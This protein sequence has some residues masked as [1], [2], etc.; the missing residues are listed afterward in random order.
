MKRQKR[1]AAPISVPLQ[2]IT[3]LIFSIIALPLMVSV[4]LF[5]L[6]TVQNQKTSIREANKSV[7]N[8]YRA[9]LNETLSQAESY[10]A[11]I[12]ANDVDFKCIMYAKSQ[13]EMYLRS[14]ELSKRSSDVLFTSPMITG[15]FTY[16]YT[17]DTPRFSYNPSVNVGPQGSENP[18]DYTWDDHLKIK[19]T[20]LRAGESG[21]SFPQWETLQLSGRRV[22]IYICV[23][24]RTAVGVI[25][26]PAEQ[27]YA[28]LNEG[29]RIFYTDEEGVP[30]ASEMLRSKEDFPVGSQENFLD[31]QGE[32]CALTALPLES[33]PGYIAYIS[34]ARSFIEELDRFQSGL[35]LFSICLILCIPLCWLVLVFTVF[36]PMSQ[37]N[38]ISKKIQAGE[39]EQRVSVDSVVKEVQIM[40]QSVNLMLDTIQRQR[41]AVYEQQLETQNAQIQYLQL[42]I[43]PHFFLNCLNMIYSLAEEKKSAQIQTL[44]IDFSAY[45]RA[46]FKDNS[47]LVTV[48]TELK[49]VES[50]IRIQKSGAQMPVEL[51]LSI[52]AGLLSLPI[53]AL[54]LL[55]FVENS[56]KHGSIQ[57]EPLSI[58]I[59]GFLFEEEGGGTYLNFSICDNGGGFRPESLESLNEPVRRVYTGQHV[60]ITNIKY[61]LQFLY[62]GRATMLLSNLTNG[63]CVELFLPLD[64]G[65]TGGDLE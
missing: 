51:S 50:Y 33:V 58:K 65:K 64:S 63:A 25:I 60:G 38:V 56:V 29:C 41:I 47:Q 20:L 53:P 43:R 39:I 28:Q 16:S 18:I 7:L 49:L 30:Y 32:R 23:L 5:C 10:L 44:V 17:F 21:A 22:F 14:Y 48:S 15:F 55:T 35:M 19:E 27:E 45:V 62:G 59:K 54:S 57:D 40:V 13:K 37:L 46:L 1:Q 61:R 4:I 12:I 26:D 42:Q 11:D 9:Q 8:V 36:K 31:C 34:P 2:R 24:R 3:L 6:Y 52:D